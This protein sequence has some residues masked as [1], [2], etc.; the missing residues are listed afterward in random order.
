MGAYFGFFMGIFFAFQYGWEQ[1]LLGGAFGGFF[2]GLWMGFFAYLGSLKFTR[3]RP[4][5]AA[6][7]IIEEGPAN[8]LGE[9]GWIYLTD[10][11]LFYVSPKLS[12]KPDE[13]SFPLSDIV[14]AEINRT[15]GLL[16]NKL[17]LHLRD[18]KR[19]EFISLDAYN[20]VNKIKR[21]SKLSLAAPHENL[22]L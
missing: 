5:N 22:Y 19:E 12:L 14:S 4:L 7:K 20:W 17:I 10:S 13:L 3:N 6:E 9:A 21:A 11:R 18:G 2:F 8:H 16:P 1:G 15:F